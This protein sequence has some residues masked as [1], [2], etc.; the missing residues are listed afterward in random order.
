MVR[1]GMIT[2]GHLGDYRNAIVVCASCHKHFDRTS[3]TRWLFLPA[4]LQWFIDWEEED[5]AERQRV[6]EQSGRRIARKF[7]SEED[8]ERHLRMENILT[9]PDDGMCRGG[10]YNSY[11][12]ESMFSPMEMKALQREGLTIPGSLPRGAKRW[13]GAPMAAINRGFVVTGAP[14]MKLPEKEWE[15]L[16]TLQRLYT[17]EILE[18]NENATGGDGGTGGGT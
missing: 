15:E 5:F 12:L 14:W 2:F 11:I 4:D 6:F 16:R 9:D 7:P 3:N 8:Y 1:K 18:L 13:H 10:L 17:R